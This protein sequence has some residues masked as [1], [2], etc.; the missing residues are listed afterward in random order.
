MLNLVSFIIQINN[1]GQ[2]IPVV[3]GVSRSRKEESFNP[4][5]PDDVIHSLYNSNFVKLCMKY[6]NDNIK[7]RDYV[8]ILAKEIATA[9]TLIAALIVQEQHG[10]HN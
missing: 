2:K 7:D 5:A 4:D 3:I 1:R 10:R 8:A 6:Q 9:H